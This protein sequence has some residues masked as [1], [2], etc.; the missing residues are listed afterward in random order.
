MRLI[1]AGSKVQIL[2]GPAPK[3]FGAAT[4]D[5]NEG[6]QVE[7]PFRRSKSTA[8]QARKETLGVQSRAVLRHVILSRA[9]GEGPHT[10][11]VITQILVWNRQHF[12]RSFALALAS[13][14]QARKP[15]S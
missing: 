14:R 7:D 6:G 5:G 2:S 12:A 13:G 15:G 1:S 10:S 4:P 8:W 11:F 9:D 3:A